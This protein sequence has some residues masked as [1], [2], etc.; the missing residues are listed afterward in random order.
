[1]AVDCRA[2]LRGEGEAQVGEAVV[3]DPRV[4]GGHR[5]NVPDTRRERNS[6]AVQGTLRVIV[7]KAVREPL[8]VS[9]CAAVTRGVGLSS[10]GRFRPRSPGGPSRSTIPD[11]RDG[12][13][14]SADAT[15][16]GWERQGGLSTFRG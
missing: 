5:R 4:R 1:M 8:P 6:R 3:D 9:R 16:A 14:R 10:S 12:V 11:A 15:R 13:W 2:G 7:P